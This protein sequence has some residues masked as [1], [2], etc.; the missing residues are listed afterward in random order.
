MS[1][2]PENDQI[3]QR[4]AKLNGLQA[5]DVRLECL[6]GR[7]DAE[8]EFEVRQRADVPATGIDGEYTEFAIDLPPEI[9]GLQYYKLRMYPYNDALSHPLELGCMIWV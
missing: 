8:G 1:D 3:A 9:A 2:T 7:K 4:R 5:E 6:F